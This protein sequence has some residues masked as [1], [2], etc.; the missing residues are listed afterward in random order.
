MERILLKILK[1]HIVEY[2]APFASY[3]NLYVDSVIY[4][5]CGELFLGRPAL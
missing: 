2:S 1:R 3:S 5:E 4:V